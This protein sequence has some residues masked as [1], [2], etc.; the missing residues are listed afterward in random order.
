MRTPR[1]PGIGAFAHSI[2]AKTRRWWILREEICWCS[3]GMRSRRRV[4][5]E[6]SQARNWQ[7]TATNQFISSVIALD[8]TSYRQQRKPYEV[9]RQ[10][11]RFISLFLTPT[12]LTISPPSTVLNL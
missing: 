11:R 2:G 5:T 9:I 3:H 8:R 1:I 7:K 12:I 6:E 10:R 4:S